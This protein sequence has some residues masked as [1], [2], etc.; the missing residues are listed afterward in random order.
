[1]TQA[2]YLF[3]LA[4]GDLPP[5]VEGAGLDG[6]AELCLHQ[7]ASISAITSPVSL[8]DFSGQAAE[9][10]LKDPAWLGPR[11]CRHEEVVEKVMKISPVLPLRFGT[12]FS[13]LES[14]EKRINAHR[15]AILDFLAQVAGREEWAVKGYL[16]RPLALREMVAGKL[17]QEEARLRDMNPGQ[18][19]FEEK[20]VQVASQGHLREWLQEVCHEVARGLGQ[21]TTGF[22]RRKL[23]PSP[24]QGSN[25]EMVANWAFLVPSERKESFQAKLQQE[26]ESFAASGL[27]FEQSGPWPPYSFAP[28]LDEDL[29]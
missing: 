2:V 17:A 23:Q 20:K 24:A 29:C 27:S 4:A 21:H 22:C 28:A 3:C 26:G 1:M 6:A 16:D 25:L 12:I 7:T 13:S 14:L 5:Q 9:K 10:N 11:I 18:R 19:Y 8:E 15:D